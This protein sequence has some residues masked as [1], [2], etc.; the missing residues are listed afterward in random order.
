MSLTA[1]DIIRMREVEQQVL[2]SA[3]RNPDAAQQWPLSREDFS[4]PAHGLI[5][6]EITTALRKGDPS[7]PVSVGY[8]LDEKHP[9]Q[10]LMA[11]CG[12][13][14]RDFFATPTT[15]AHAAKIVREKGVERATVRLVNKF[16]SR[17]IDQHELVAGLK[18]LA[19]QRDVPAYTAAHGLRELMDYMGDPPKPIPTGIDRLDDQF[20][21][22]HRGDLVLLQARPAIGKTAI[23]ITLARNM[24]AQGV[25]ALFY[26]GEMPAGQIMARLVAMEARVPAYK[27][28]SGKLSDEQWAK[29]TKAATT[30][31]DHPLYISYKAVPKLAD[32]I[33]VAHRMKEQKDIQILFVDYAQRINVARHESRRDAQI[34]IAQAM[35][36]LAGELDICIVLLAQSGRQVDDYNPKSWGQMPQMGDVQESAAY[37]QE[38]DM[39]IGLARDGVNAMLDVQKNRHGPTGMVPLEFIGPT[40]EFRSVG[41]DRPVSLHVA[42][43]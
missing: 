14:A 41:A 42:K 26:T 23:A 35:K 3:F 25:P 38:A 37:E 18:Q 31:Q 43:K 16:A 34:Q 8:V 10:G 1:H 12:T 7:D 2:G 24:V 9:G 5:W 40:M 27:F 4:D 15:G 21:G 30:I 13:I 28:R 22:L 19:M 11:S 33:N 6:E 36:G 17:L 32:I 39:M 20:S 29:F